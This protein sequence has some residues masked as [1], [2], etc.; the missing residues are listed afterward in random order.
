[1]SEVSSHLS[2]IEHVKNNRQANYSD[3]DMIRASFIERLLLGGF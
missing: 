1:M 3:M 2:I